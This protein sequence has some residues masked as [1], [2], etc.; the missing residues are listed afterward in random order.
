MKAL[1]SKKNINDYTFT[2]EVSVAYINALRELFNSGEIDDET[3]DILSKAKLFKDD[4]L[5]VFNY[6]KPKTN[7]FKISSDVKRLLVLWSMHNI[8]A[9][10]WFKNKTYVEYLQ[11]MVDK[12]GLEKMQKI[13]YVIIPLG[14]DTPMVKTIEN[15]F[16]LLSAI[17]TGY[18]QNAKA[19]GV[20]NDNKEIIKRKLL[21]LEK[22][23]D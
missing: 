9:K 2:D 4:K 14:N 5:R 18:I 8:S 12:H 10:T 7:T 6:K 21:E 22:W 23:E 16:D 15:P 13:V 3:K 11:M 1:I 19:Q 20:F 17:D